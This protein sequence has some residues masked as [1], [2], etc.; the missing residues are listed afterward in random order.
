MLLNIL[1]FVGVTYLTIQ[2]YKDL[3]EILKDDN[4]LFR[5]WKKSKGQIKIFVPYFLFLNVKF[6]VTVLPF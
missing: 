2:C 6:N 1:L 5:D 3:K 4:E